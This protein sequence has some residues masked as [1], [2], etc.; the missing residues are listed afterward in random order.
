MALMR[1][2]VRWEYRSARRVLERGLQ[3]MLRAIARPSL[4]ERAS[5]VAI[6]PPER[7]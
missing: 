3:G 5:S 7:P 4:P 1:Q 6:Q 2:L